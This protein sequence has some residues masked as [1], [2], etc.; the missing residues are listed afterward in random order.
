MSNTT[1]SSTVLI[2]IPGFISIATHLS[3]ITSA[4]LA[5][6]KNSLFLR[7]EL[8]S[9]NFAPTEAYLQSPWAQLSRE[10]SQFMYFVCLSMVCGSFRMVFLSSNLG[11][12]AIQTFRM[13]LARFA[14]LRFT[15]IHAGCVKQRHT[16]YVHIWVAGTSAWWKMGQSCCNV[17][18]A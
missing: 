17:V 11:I 12:S 13:S 4:N 18:E 8:F 1:L 14:K 7:Q 10:V 5:I 9:A 3:R 16:L 6:T 15:P 2:V